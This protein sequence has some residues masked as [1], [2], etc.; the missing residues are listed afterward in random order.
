MLGHWHVSQEYIVKGITGK[1]KGGWAVGC[2]SDL[3]P[4]YN[5]INQW[6]HGFAKITKDHNSFEVDNKKIINGKIR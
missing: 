2:L 4:E 6:T 1:V 5:P 3:Y